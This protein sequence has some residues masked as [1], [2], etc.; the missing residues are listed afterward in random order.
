MKRLATI[1]AGTAVL[2]LG[3]CGKGEKAPEKPQTVQQVADEIKK[4]S[5]QPGEWEV[6][7][8]VTDV[9]VE[10]APKDMPAEMLTAMKGRKV[11]AKKCIT[12][13]EASKPS[14]SF[15]ASQKDSRCTYKG[16]EMA[17]G[18]IRGEVSCPGETGGTVHIATTGSYGRDRYD[19]TGTMRMQGMGGPQMPNMTMVMTVKTVG[20]RIGE[21]PAGAPAKNAAPVPP[22]G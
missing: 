3:A 15:L 16:F 18:H 17:G 20:R 8:E 11:S 14:A 19:M 1:M 6:G 12:P 4:I 21:C 9:T 5:L 2:A 7:Q 22:A 10:G 13:E